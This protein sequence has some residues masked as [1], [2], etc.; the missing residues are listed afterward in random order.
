MIQTIEA[1]HGRISGWRKSG[2]WRK[3]LKSIVRS[4][5]RACSSGGKNKESRVKSIAETYIH[6]SILLS[7]KLKI[8]VP[9]LPVFNAVDLATNMVLEHYHTLLDKHINLVNRRLLNGET[10][11]QGEKMFSIFETYT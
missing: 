6:K 9:I 3:E 1:K 10:I 11:P 2:S 7:T 5:G 8:T 4:L